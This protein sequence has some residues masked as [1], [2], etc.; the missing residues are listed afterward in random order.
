LKNK[1]ILAFSL[2]LFILILDQSVKIYV[3]THFLLGEEYKIFGLERALLHFVENP[4]MAF[5][6]EFGGDYGKLA[7]SLFR[8]VA[9]GFLVYYIRSL[10]K[11]G[12]ST[13][14]VLSFA[15]ILA[16]ALGNIIDSAFYGMIFNN[17]VPE[18]HGGEYAQLFPPEGGY[19]TFLHGRVVDMFY[20]PLVEGVYPAWMPSEE[21]FLGKFLPNAGTRY[22]FFQPV[23]NV[24]DA[25]I[26]VGVASLI[27]FQRSYF[28]D[29]ETSEKILVTHQE[30][31]NIASIEEENA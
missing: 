29:Q 18:M 26:T 5:G 28:A 10:V 25:A 21:S 22:Q 27:L 13:G 15:L 11:T 31:E 16:G 4:G 17:S 30:E 8:I 14:L 6:M 3:K 19:G 2:I 9:V 23:F 20:F 7:L 12:A 24:A 1:T